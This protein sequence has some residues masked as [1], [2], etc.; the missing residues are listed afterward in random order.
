LEQVGV[1]RKIIHVRRR[2]TPVLND[3]VVNV[4]NPF[5]GISLTLSLSSPIPL[6][7]NKCCRQPIDL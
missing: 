6:L 7:I 1:N 3:G 2:G 5:S 4:E